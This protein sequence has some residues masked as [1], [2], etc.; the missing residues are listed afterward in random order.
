MRRSAGQIRAKEL[1]DINYVEVN[2]LRLQSPRHVFSHIWEQLTGDR[3]GRSAVG[4]PAHEGM[5]SGWRL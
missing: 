2:G 5:G 4:P 1:P 3:Q